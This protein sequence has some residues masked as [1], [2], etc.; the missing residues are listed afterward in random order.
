MP[1]VEKTTDPKESRRYI[2]ELVTL[3]ALPA[4][5]GDHSPEQVAESIADVLISILDAEFIYTR[6]CGELWERKFDVLRTSSRFSPY[7]ERLHA[8]LLAFLPKRPHDQT[9][10][11]TGLY[12]DEI[13]RIVSVPIGFGGNAVL[14]AGDSR[15]NFPTEAQH[16]LLKIVSTGMA[17]ALRCWRAENEELRFG[18]LVKNS[19]AFIAFASLDGWPQYVNLAGMKLV[20]IETPERVYQTHLLEF[21]CEADRQRARDEIWPLVMRAGH[22]VGELNFRHFE[23]GAEIASF[24]DWLRIDDPRTGKP[25]NHAWVS[26]DLTAHKAS[27]AKLR[28]L[29]A[30]LEQR[31]VNRTNQLAAASSKLAAETLHR[32]VADKR[33]HEV[34]LNY[35]HAQRLATAGQM[36]AAMAHELNQPLTA[37]TTSVSSA[38]RFMA[39]TNFQSPDGVDE[40][41]SEA[42]G[43]VL[44]AGQIIDR[45]RDLVTRGESEYRLEDLSALIH[46]ASGLAVSGSDGYALKMNF[47]L[48]SDVGNVLCNRVQIQQVLVNLIRNAIEAI[49]MSRPGVVTISTKVLD[50]DNVEVAIADN[51][52][53]LPQ[54]VLDRLFEP[55]V[56][57]KTDGMGLG[58]SICR[59]IVE[60]HGGRL[61]NEANCNGGTIFRFTLA[62]LRTKQH[63]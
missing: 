8:A 30:S 39:R 41:L 34:Q 18:T 57:T 35:F 28:D 32:Q 47:Q 42:A 50:A 60:A 52:P 13:L 4:N 33:L 24:V 36:A 46:E 58:L 26:R 61:S 9:T 17:T 2:R 20:G 1:W 49:G 12:P 22:W 11:T 6:L 43:Q 45:L 10:E 38:R 7:T 14:V 3:S 62:P 44:R 31:V 23:T 48:D 40:A 21:I 15:A 37:I 55:F 5:W 16:L 25:M 56:S 29:N 51:G 63:R 53:G 19:S 27:E 54:L 59:S